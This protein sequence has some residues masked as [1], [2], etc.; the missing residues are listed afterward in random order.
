MR[1]EHAALDHCCQ[2]RRDDHTR[3][4]RLVEVANDL[5]DREGNGGDGCIERGRD[6]GGGAHGDQTSPV[7][8]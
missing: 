4:H 8:R 5:L 2:R 6:P 7:P 1:P 3:E